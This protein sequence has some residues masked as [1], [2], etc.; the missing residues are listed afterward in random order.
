MISS[1]GKILIFSKDD[2]IVLNI[3]PLNHNDIICT[4]DGCG[5]C[6]FG[7]FLLGDETVEIEA[8]W[9][10]ILLALLLPKHID[11][12]SR[13]FGGVALRNHLLVHALKLHFLDGKLGHLV[14]RRETR[15]AQTQTLLLRLIPLQQLFLSIFFCLPRTLFLV[16]FE[17]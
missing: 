10:F 17:F 12:L 14:H 13:Q 3:I 6:F 2:L 5:H 8:P 15:S 16:L 11:L 9:G 1:N 4:F 7:G